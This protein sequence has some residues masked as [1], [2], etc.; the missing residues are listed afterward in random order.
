MRIL[1][2]DGGGIKGY[3]PATVLAKLESQAGK[4]V[5]AMTDMLAGTSTGAIL[6]L[7]LAAGIPAADLAAFYKAKAG[8]IFRRT[9]GRRLRSAFGLIDEQYDSDGLRAGLV[10]IFGD[11]TLAD[12]S[13]AGPAVLVVAY[14]IEA[15]RPVFFASW[16]AHRDHCRDFSL[17]D[18]AMASAAAP[19]YFEPVEIMSRGGDRLV[20]VDGGIAANNPALCAAVELVKQDAPTS[21]A[22]LV[23]LGTGREDKPYM[24]ARA[25]NWG[26]AGWARPIIDCMFSATSDVTD[27]QCRHLLGE[28]YVR[29]QAD[30]SEAVAM[31]AT[32]DR[33][34]AVMRL[35]AERIAE[36][37]EFYAALRLLQEGA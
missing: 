11:K 21:R 25:R 27:H 5:S 6:A 15:R 17:V 4:P 32:D 2:I 14:E 23:S 10:E 3:L 36:R 30:L 8:A 33:A 1:S 13:R 28:R 29:L 35:H 26:L 22:C 16:D 9:L 20:C 12:L 18:V 24:L 37:A 7:G 31:D 19:T 34:F